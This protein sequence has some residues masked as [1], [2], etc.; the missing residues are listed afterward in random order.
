MG[1]ETRSSTTRRQIFF[2][3]ENNKNGIKMKCQTLFK[4]LKI[5]SE[6]FSIFDNVL[7]EY[8]IL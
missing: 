2:M 4:F 8:F 3:E 7:I 5:L 1:E 6:A